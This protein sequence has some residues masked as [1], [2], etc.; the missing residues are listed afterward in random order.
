MIAQMPNPDDVKKAIRLRCANCWG[1]MSFANQL[2][3][4]PS[5]EWVLAHSHTL[6]E[7]LDHAREAGIDLT[8]LEAAVEGGPIEG[9][10]YYRRATGELSE[11]E[12]RAE[13]RKWQKGE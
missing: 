13:F 4:Y 10:M 5:P 11:T 9:T 3:G 2:G 6:K 12:F 1:A 8:G 7:L